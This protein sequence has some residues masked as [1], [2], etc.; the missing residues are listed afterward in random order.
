MS[1]YR[2]KD[3]WTIDAE[4]DPFHAC[5]DSRCKKCN[6]TIFR[7]SQAVGRGRV[8]EAF[9]WGAYNGKTEEYYE[10]YST[11]DLVDF[12]R[13]KRTLIYAHNGGK[14]DYHFLRDEINSD[15]PIMVINGRLARFRIGACEFRDSLNIFPATRLSDFGGKLEIDYSLMEPEQRTNPNNLAEIK[16]Y[17]RQDCV[18]LWQQ[19]S[20][21]RSEFGTSLTQATASMKYWEKLSEQEA[22]RQTKT[23]HTRYRPFYYGGRVQS[24]ECGVKTVL[25]RMADINS[26]YPFGMLFKHP[27]SAEAISETELPIEAKIGPCLIE[28]DASSRG[29]L[30]WRNPEDGELF[31]P[32]DESGRR[33]KKRRYRITGWELIAGLELNQIQ[34]HKIHEVHVFPQTIDFR[35]YIEHF[36]ERREHARRIGDVAGRQHCKYFMNGLYG[37]FGANCE[38]YA[39]YVIASAELDAQGEKSGVVYWK[40]QGFQIYKEWGERYLMCRSPS[41]EQ[42]ENANGRWRYYNVATAASVTGFVR[43]HLWKAANQCSGLVY[44]DTDSITARDTSRL[45]FGNALGEWKDEGEFDEIAIAGKKL[46]AMHRRNKER[47]YDPTVNEKDRTWKIASKG[48]NYGSMVNGPEIIARIAQGEEVTYI[49]QVPTYTITRER[50]RF[51]A[52]TLKNTYKDIRIAPDALIV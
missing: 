11:H 1:W 15:E 32:E 38:N 49:P 9:I 40:T 37:K 14:F 10:F 20:R 23:Q 18:L 24:F 43:A 48:V 33:C 12:F 39:E 27:F 42:L 19:V 7:E 51:I 28:M 26:A 2:G 6:T 30:P 5:T 45:K 16:K 29:A 47:N 17:L 41:A 31:F 3:F 8:P 13:H 25:C 35:G 52:R 22:P 46:Y 34:I 50:P 4:T 21:Y 44:M 36:F